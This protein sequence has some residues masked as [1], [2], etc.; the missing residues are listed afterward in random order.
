MKPRFDYGTIGGFALGLFAI[1]GVF[2]IEGGNFYA[3]ASVSAMTIVFGGTVATVLIGSSHQA[4]LHIG[5][6]IKLV[7]MPP[8]LDYSSIIE[9]LVRYATVARRD[10]L[11]MLE[12]EMSKIAQPFMRKVMQHAIDGTEPDLLH[13]LGQ[14]ELESYRQQQNKGI[15]LFQK[16]GGYSPT[17]GI[18]GTVLGLIVA[19]ASA[20]AEPDK[21]IQHISS[22]FIATL[23]GVFMA[24]VV[25]LPI[26]DKLRTLYEEENLQ[27]EIMLEGVK[28]IQAGDTPTMTRSRLMSLLPPEMKVGKK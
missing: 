12:K 17:M 20:G 28:A 10:G 11:L 13:S 22:A 16:M 21:L 9:N 27:Y 5:N 24:N 26:A 8:E 4:L 3:V 7:T 14:M 18:I 25:W 23:W 6:L 2:L 15:Q 1:F 19:L